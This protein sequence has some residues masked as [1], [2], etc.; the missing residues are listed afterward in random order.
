LDL[1]FTSRI[2]ERLKQLGLLERY[3]QTLTKIAQSE[4]LPEEWATPKQR[5][6]AALK[7]MKSKK[8]ERNGLRKK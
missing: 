1:K 7:T 8:T 4:C 2:E 5:C 6:Q 3:T